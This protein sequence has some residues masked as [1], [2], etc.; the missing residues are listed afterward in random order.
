MVIKDNNSRAGSRLRNNLR[1]SNTSSDSSGKTIKDD[2]NHTNH[3]NT[4][5][6]SM[7]FKEIFLII[8]IIVFSI[9][10]FLIIKPYMSNIISAVVLS[11]VFYPIYL[12]IKSR[13]DNSSVAASIMILIVLLM[14][15]IPIAYVA[16]QLMAQT[17]MVINNVDNVDTS[18]LDELTMKLSIILGQEILFEDFLIDLSSSGKEFIV[19]AAPQIFGSLSSIVLGL[20]IM[21]FVMY[22]L[23]K[24]GDTLVR[25]ILKLSP[26]KEEHEQK[27]VDEVGK[28]TRGVVYGQVIVAVL[29]GLVAGI[30]YAF[31]GVTA[32]V[33]WAFITLIASFLP[34]IGTALIWLPISIVMVLSGNYVGGLLL[35]AYCAL[36]VVN[37]DNVVRPKLIG[38][39]TGLHP[40]LVLLGVL[41]GLNMFGFIGLVVGPVIISIVIIL[42]KLYMDDYR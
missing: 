4:L 31:F 42:L 2:V 35:A 27:L 23:F 26:I 33:L 20:F 25:Y 14:V 36:V 8:S 7:A 38:D 3:V 21:L 37:I 11:F 13:F 1:K 17:V 10:T 6:S 12:K 28:V 16:S 5:R 18:V 9:F 32:P 34:V 39:R 29:Q 40:V 24:D 41:G 19:S 22:Y 30:G 15:I